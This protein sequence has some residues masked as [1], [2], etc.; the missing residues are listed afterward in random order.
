MKLIDRTHMLN[1]VN[2]LSEGMGEN[3][4]KNFSFLMLSDTETLVYT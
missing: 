4:T 2:G 3:K 1:I